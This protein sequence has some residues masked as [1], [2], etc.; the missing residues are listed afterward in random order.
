MKYMKKMKLY[1]S[2]RWTDAGLL[3][4]K[5]KLEKQKTLKQKQQKIESSSS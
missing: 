3:Y 4:D 1:K 2:L 5:I